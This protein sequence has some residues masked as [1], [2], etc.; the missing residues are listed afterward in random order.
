ML[1]H[2]MAKA[3]TCRHQSL[4]SRRAYAAA[5]AATSRE[6]RALN[7]QQL[8][9]S[10]KEASAAVPTSATTPASAPAS[11]PGQAPATA[12]G[13]GGGAPSASGGGG[14]GAMLGL[15]AV[16]GA[17]GALA[18]YNGMIPGLGG[19]E[20]K[21]P[22]KKEEESAKAVVVADDASTTSEETESTTDDKEDKDNGSVTMD[23]NGAGPAESGEVSDEDDLAEATAAA[24][25]DEAPAPGLPTGKES[26]A[27]VIVMEEEAG[28]P[29]ALLAESKIME[30]LEKVKAQLSKES[31]RALS[32]A[33]SEL[34]KLS[35]LNLDN[36]DDMT[37]TQLK[38]RLV[39]M[40]K[41]ME[42][43]T[44]WEAVRLQEF[45]HMKEK[46]VEDK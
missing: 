36:L 3:A 43:R 23:K 38:V 22:K 32:E 1:R 42:D 35:I 21:E 18:Y 46:E 44:K 27:T 30:E 10:V 34:A 13:G 29:K 20:K 41:E 9:G 25:K 2:F 28:P 39:Q 26:H 45:L 5:A 24:A 15:L 40:A 37:T 14:G 12:S 16:V 17:G 11:A 6:K 31:D 19:E 4:A 7:K 33:H 8:Q